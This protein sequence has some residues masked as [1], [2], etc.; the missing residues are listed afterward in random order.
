MDACLY[1]A[2]LFQADLSWADE[3]LG[4]LGKPIYVKLT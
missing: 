3:Q 1:R 2:S 4:R